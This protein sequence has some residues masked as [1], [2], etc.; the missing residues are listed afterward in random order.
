MPG[1]EFQASAEEA[2]AAGAKQGD[3][4]DVFFSHDGRLVWKWTNYLTVYERHFA[5]FRT[6]FPLPDGTRRPLRFLEIGVY[7][8]G[9]LQMW[10]KY[11]GPEAVIFGVDIDPRCKAVDDEDLR[12]RIGS[13]DDPV[14]LRD[15]VAEMRGV[16]IVVDDG[17]HMPMHQRTSFRA[18]FPLVSDGGLYV[19]EDLHCAYWSG[20]EGG[21]RRRGTFIEAGK[22]LVDGIHAWYFRRPP[23]EIAADAKTTISSV[24][25][26]DNVMVIE[27][28]LHGHS[29][30]VQVG[31]PSF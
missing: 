13:Q 29:T 14:F 26:Y 19:V 23:R 1:G 15:V 7:H 5:P 25:F 24:M 20:Y 6:G 8:G 11:F 2:I 21:L 4:A 27:K 18:L 10:R 12:V 31:H 28:R 3:L 22:D 17:S 16:D 9:S 30:A